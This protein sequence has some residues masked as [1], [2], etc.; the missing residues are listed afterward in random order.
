MRLRVHNNC[1]L[2][3]KGDPSSSSPHLTITLQLTNLSLIEEPQAS[4]QSYSS[5]CLQ[6]FYLE[7]STLVSLLWNFVLLAKIVHP[8]FAQD[9]L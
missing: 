3:K 9:R 6:S 7:I 5:Y 4:L 8:N 1:S 2:H